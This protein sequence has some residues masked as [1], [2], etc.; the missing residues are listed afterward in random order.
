MDGR[1]S[2]IERDR[3]TDRQ[4]ERENSQ[5][6]KQWDEPTDI[7]DMNGWT[8]RGHVSSHAVIISLD[9]IF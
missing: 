8:Q 9:E 2:A 4:R 3:Q 1:E 7:H 6:L 5:N